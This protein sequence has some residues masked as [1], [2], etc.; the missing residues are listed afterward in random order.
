M[1]DTS[2]ADVAS[3]TDNK[4]NDY[5]AEVEPDIIRGWNDRRKAS[6]IAISG[7]TPFVQLIGLFSEKEIQKMFSFDITNTRRKVYFD[8]GETPSS[9]GDAQEG[10]AEEF[11]A[12]NDIIRQINTRAINIYFSGTHN[13]EG[14]GAPVRGIILGETRTQADPNN[15]KGGV[16][17]TDLQ[18]DY[19]KSSAV[20]SRTYKMRLTVN[21]PKLFNE[22]VEYSKLATMGGEFVILYGWT[23]PTSIPGFN[24]LPVPSPEPDNNVPGKEKIVIPLNGQGTGGYWQAAKMNILSYDFSFNELGQ[25]EIAVSF[26][27]KT[28]LAL[29]TQKVGPSASVMKKILGA[30]EYSTTAKEAGEPDTPT[31]GFGSTQITIGDKTMTYAEAIATNQE[32]NIK[33]VFEHA[34]SNVGYVPNDEGMSRV[35]ST[36]DSQDVSDFAN[37]FELNVDD[38]FTGM[39]EAAPAETT[40]NIQEFIRR[41][42]E[43]QLNEFPY[44]G[45]GIRVYEKI[46][47]MAVVAPDEF[48]EAT[49]N[50]VMEEVPGYNIKTTHYYFGWILEA[51]KLGMQNTNKHKIR[52]GEAPAI[53]NFTYLDN[54]DA[55]QIT[56]V[57]Q[58]KQAARKH[59]PI[60]QRVQDAII[61]LK[62]KCIP[63]FRARM[64][65]EDVVSAVGG[66]PGDAQGNPINFETTPC[67]NTIVV[68][69]IHLL[70]SQ[71]DTTSEEII[72]QIK[73]QTGLTDEDLEA[74]QAPA[75]DGECY[76]GHVTEVTINLT[77][78]RG[79][80]WFGP[81]EGE[82]RNIQR[83]VRCFIPDPAFDPQNPTDYDIT[84]SRLYKPWLLAL[85]T[86]RTSRLQ[87]MEFN[88]DQLQSL[89]D[90]V[91][92]PSELP[93]GQAGL[94]FAIAN[95][96]RMRDEAD[97]LRAQVE[98]LGSDADKPPSVQQI[99]KASADNARQQGYIGDSDEDVV[100]GKFFFF[101]R[102][103]WRKE[104]DNAGIV[105]GIAAV[106]AGGGLSPIGMV[107][108][109]A[110]GA[111]YQ[112]LWRSGHVTGVY[113]LMSPDQARMY[114]NWELIQR[115]WYNIHVKAITT[116]IE[117]II[118][119][120]MDELAA[121]GRSV[122]D[123]YLEPVDLDWVTSWNF[124]WSEL[125]KDTNRIKTYDQIK[126]NWLRDNDVPDAVEPIT[127]RIE[128]Y[129]KDI[130]ELNN[131]IADVGTRLRGKLNFI[132]RQKEQI[133][134][135]TGGR[136]DRFLDF[137]DNTR[138]GNSFYN[139]NNVVDV[140]KDYDAQQQERQEENNLIVFSETEDVD[141]PVNDNSEQRIEPPLPGESDLL[142]LDTQEIDEDEQR[143]GRPDRVR[144]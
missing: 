16:G 80:A 6:N 84:K 113:K 63:P 85:A 12:Y 133:E 143:Q 106:A 116:E 125:V 136:F 90:D 101:L 37:F 96:Q 64:P 55:D 144:R 25:I 47:K 21:D 19:G 79:H 31:D 87:T 126:G 111:A 5:T 128:D 41:D 46:T 99:I 10:S 15:H 137:E 86:N 94:D 97:Q 34:T 120:R 75:N 17:I 71:T 38:M 57:F 24:S 112:Q 114:V 76:R 129:D 119:R 1:S 3:D 32:D 121:E 68:E 28:S 124:S 51:M 52:M 93:L 132:E 103:E 98:R 22:Q 115:K 138:R 78:Q 102:C 42:K 54:P 139:F 117:Q 95:V 62:E 2:Y 110:A 44:A 58:S 7:L 104:P 33:A 92:D 53:P 20:G 72:D 109:A 39:N 4:L 14:R 100:R 77:V 88:I 89:I 83:T 135:K 134:R 66:K 26:I 142:F 18:I 43:K 122:E 30:E 45:S 8:D 60:D 9:L 13:P 131:A 48:D 118:Y 82:A 107:A 36:V 27:D 81:H 70:L 69:N 140:M 11:N 108:G 73:N 67:K 105:G 29:A 74:M 127:K 35:L 141:R 130:D 23:N 49:G 61:R 40:Q 65:D 91:E 56:N 123:I 59:G 50:P